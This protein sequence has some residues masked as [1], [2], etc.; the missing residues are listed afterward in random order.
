MD[1]TIEIDLMQIMGALLRQVWWIILAAVVMGAAFFGYATHFITPLYQS[2]ALMYVNNSSYALNPNNPTFAI[3]SSEL[4][5]AQS[6]V[7]TYIVILKTKTTMNDVIREA[8]LDYSVK[9]LMSMISASAVNDT[10]V[11]SVKV[12]SPDP[13]E[14]RLIADTIANVL[15]GKIA[16]VVDGSSVRQVDYVSMSGE[17]TSPNITRYTAIGIL[18]GALIAGGIIVLHELMNTQ[19]RSEDYLIQTYELPILAVIPNLFIGAEAGYYDY[20]S[21]RD[22]AEG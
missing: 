3:S 6:L 2:E 15:P 10:E 8:E 17:K 20:K 21:T 4:T 5:A 11:F 1:N 19:V 16:A 7:E 22:A 18:I 14:A 13:E 12:T 9:E